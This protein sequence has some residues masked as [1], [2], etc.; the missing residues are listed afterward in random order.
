MA[1]PFVHR[2]RVRYVECDMQG[3]VF[4]G[5]YLTYLDEAHT[6]LLRASGGQY[7]ALLEEGRDLVVAEAGLRFLASAHFDDQLAIEVVV[8]QLTD[9]SM[10]SRFAVRRDGEL[11][12]EATLRHV[13]VARD[14]SG[15][16]RWPAAFRAALAQ[17]V[18]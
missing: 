8:E 12:T 16:A 14:G 1:E 10:T 7:A 15:K 3:H 17:R 2:L 11:L 9:S 4:N 13:C 6:E 5:H 18:A